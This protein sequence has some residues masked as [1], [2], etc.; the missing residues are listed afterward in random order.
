MTP[1]QH[2]YSVVASALNISTKE[3]QV[4]ISAIFERSIV[5]KPEHIVREIGTIIGVDKL[6]DILIS[7]NEIM[8]NENLTIDTATRRK[9]NQ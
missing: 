2:F 1:E 8:Y 6:A 3:Q 9:N 5:Q 4:R 7:L